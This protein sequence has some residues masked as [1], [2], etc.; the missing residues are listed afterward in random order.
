MYFTVFLNKDD[1]DDSPFHRGLARSVGQSCA[2]LG[3]G[4]GKTER[5][6]SSVVTTSLFLLLF[7]FPLYARV[8][9]KLLFFVMWIYV[10][11]VE[12][13]GGRLPDPPPPLWI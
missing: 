2:S 5:T 8:E 1:D 4:E 13:G 9:I 12:G 3:L 10:K 11:R 7:C 6:F